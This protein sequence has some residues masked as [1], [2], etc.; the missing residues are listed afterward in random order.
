MCFIQDVNIVLVIRK[1]DTLTGVLFAWKREVEKR[2]VKVKVK[3]FTATANL[4]VIIIMVNYYGGVTKIIINI[5]F[6]I[7]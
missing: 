6:M 1:K 3:W 2:I 5:H 4:Y 7:Y